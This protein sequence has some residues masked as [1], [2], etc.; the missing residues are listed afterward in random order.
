M[1]R[2]IELIVGLPPMTQ[3][4]AAATPMLDSFTDTPNLQPYSAIVPDQPLDELNTA[5]SPMSAQSEAMDFTAEDRAP[6]QALNEAIW[7]SVRGSAS[8][9]PAPRTSFRGV[10]YVGPAVT[11]AD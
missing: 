1:L 2:T 7:Q 9:M 11:E 4:D 5:A 3:F 6:E 10:P 8:S